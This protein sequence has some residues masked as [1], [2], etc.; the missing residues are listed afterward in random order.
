MAW[1]SP[2][3]LKG[4]C[5]Y[6]RGLG[7]FL[8]DVGLTAPHLLGRLLATYILRVNKDSLMWPLRMRDLPGESLRFRMGGLSV[9]RWRPSLWLP[10]YN[11]TESL[12]HDR[13][14]LKGEVFKTT[15]LSIMCASPRQQS[16]W[17]RTIAFDGDAPLIDKWN[18]RRV[19][20]PKACEAT[21]EI[22]GYNSHPM[23]QFPGVLCLTKLY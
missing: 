12:K 4:E 6:Y 3:F 1:E 22:F 2:L 9:G 7:F 15:L 17:L 19:P 20:Q 5:I 11:T 13:F 18:S 14:L 10:K 8:L 21:S 23:S 16:L